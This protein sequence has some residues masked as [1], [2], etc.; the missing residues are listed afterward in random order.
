MRK[1]IA[2]LFLGALCAC[3]APRR[4]PSKTSTAHHAP[5]L[6]QVSSEGFAPGAM[7]PR[8]YT[9]DGRSIS[10]PL[11]WSVAP[12][13]TRSL[14]LI[15]SDPDAPGGTFTHWVIYNLPAASRGLPA[16]VPASARLRNGADQGVNDFGKN[17]YGGPCP[18][19][20]VHHYLFDLYALDTRLTPAGR[21][22]RQVLLNAMK[23]HVLGHGELM[24]RYRRQR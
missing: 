7:I 15:C 17:G 24:G 1:A 4:A 2:I 11:S 21:V 18:P 19:S 3:Q 10:P 16:D 6:M 14:A 22:T 9:C 12:R 13:G 20:G 5:A 23:D 8:E